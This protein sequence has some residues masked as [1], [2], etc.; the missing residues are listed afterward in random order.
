MLQGVEACVPVEGFRP[1]KPYRSRL[2]WR[3]LDGEGFLVSDPSLNR[4][5]ARTREA[6]LR[7]NINT[8]GGGGDWKLGLFRTDSESDIIQVAS[9]LQGRGV[10]QNVPGTRRHGLEAGALYLASSLHSFF[11]LE[12]YRPTGLWGAA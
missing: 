3:D 12:G 7:G 2:T 8:A 11:H 5:V 6:G 4:V 1:T 10:F 9:V